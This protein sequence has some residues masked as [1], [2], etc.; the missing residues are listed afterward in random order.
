MWKTEEK[1]VFAVIF[2]TFTSHIVEHAPFSR[3]AWNITCGYTIGLHRTDSL[4]FRLIGFFR[5]ENKA[6]ATTLLVQFCR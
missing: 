1:L 4:F 5:T 3:M 2:L 6:F